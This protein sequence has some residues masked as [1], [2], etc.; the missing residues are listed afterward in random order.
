[1]LVK[2]STFGVSIK[3]LREEHSLTQKELALRLGV[4]PQSISA[5][6]RNLNNPTDDLINKISNL[7]DLP[8]SQVLNYSPSKDN[9]ICN[10]KV[11][12]FNN[13]KDSIISTIF[14]F[15]RPHIIHYPLP[16]S[17]KDKYQGGNIKLVGIDGYKKGVLIIGYDDTKKDD[18]NIVSN[19]LYVYEVEGVPFISKLEKCSDFFS[20]TP[21]EIYSMVPSE[22]SIHYSDINLIG[23]LVWYSVTID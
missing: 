18:K 16:P 13:L 4:T 19:K 11:P 1:M 20:I 15:I 22:R 8:V 10:V 5:W 2:A 23:E 7:F 9:G 17:L 21:W 3:A 6:E 14:P 12:F